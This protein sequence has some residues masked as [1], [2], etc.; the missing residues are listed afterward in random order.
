[1][2]TM[3]EPS[4]AK[5]LIYVIFGV[6]MS[7]YFI[8][9]LEKWPQIG[10]FSTAIIDKNSAKIMV[11]SWP[12]LGAIL[13][14]SLVAMGHY[15]SFMKGGIDESVASLL[16]YVLCLLSFM[17]IPK[18]G[19]GLISGIN[20]L[21]CTDY[22]LEKLKKAYEENKTIEK[23][24]LSKEHIDAH[25]ILTGPKKYGAKKTIG[26]SLLLATF[27]LIPIIG[28]CGGWHLILPLILFIIAIIFPRLF[29]R[30]EKKKVIYL[31]SKKK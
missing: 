5:N 18:F 25:K 23:V 27:L 22:Y 29:L 21:F 16:F 3:I 8:E 4:I 19:A 2:M 31:T 24:Y 17:L 14:L 7:V 28:P 12:L 13:F 11:I 6:T 1:M 15:F 20:I 30:L 9:L 10:R 26:N